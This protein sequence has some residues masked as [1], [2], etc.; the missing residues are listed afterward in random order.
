VID[1][2]RL[3]GAHDGGAMARERRRTRGPI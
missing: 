3:A 2:I 1:A